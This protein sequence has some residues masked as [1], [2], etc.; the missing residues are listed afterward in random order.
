MKQIYRNR[1]P[2]ALGAARR[3]RPA[4]VHVTAAT[5]DG[6]TDGDREVRAI[7]EAPGP[8]DKKRGLLLSAPIH[9]N[10]TKNMKVS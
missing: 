5:A 9:K 7:R 3:V 2:A 1:L 6:I 8:G 10:R 4:V